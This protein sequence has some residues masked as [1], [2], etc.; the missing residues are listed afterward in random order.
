MFQLL[1]LTALALAI[2]FARWNL[3]PAARRLRVIRRIGRS[4]P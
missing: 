2:E 3:R 1:A 4:C